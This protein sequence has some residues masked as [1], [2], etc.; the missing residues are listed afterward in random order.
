MVGFAPGSA[1]KMMDERCR[2]VVAKLRDRSSGLRSAVQPLLDLQQ[3]LLESSRAGS[4]NPDHT[5]AGLLAIQD[6]IL[7]TLAA[8]YDALDA[9][10]RESELPFAEVDHTG[11]IVYANEAMARHIPQ[12][13]GRD[14]ISLFG[15]R[16]PDVGKA[17][18]REECASLRVELDCDGLPRQF[19]AEIGPLRDHEGKPGAYALLL[20]L[21]SE[22][23]RLDAALDAIMRADVTG[24][25]AFANNKALALLQL[26]REQ[27]LGTDLSQW[28][29]LREP[30]QGEPIARRIARWLEATDAITDNE[31][32]LKGAGRSHPINLAVVPSYDGPEQRSGILMTF[33]DATEDLA[34]E[35]LRRLLVSEKDPDTVI[36]EAICIV[37][38]VIPCDMATFATYSDDGQLCRA[39]LVEPRPDWHWGTRWFDVTPEGRAWLEGDETWSDDLAAMVRNLAPDQ[40]SDPVV[41]AVREEGLNKLVVLPVRGAG[42]IFRCSLSLLSSERTYGAA[43]LRAL[44]DLGLEELFLAVQAAMERQREACIQRLK[45][46]LNEAPTARALAKTLAQGVVRCFGWEYAGVFRIDR[47]AGEFE[48]FEQVDSTKDKKL[49]VESSYRQKLSDGMLGHCYRQEEVLVLPRIAVNGY[50]YDFIK[51]TG[52]QES[53]MTVPLRVNGRIEL[54]LDLEAS[55]ENAFAGPDKQLAEALVADC[56]QILASRWHEAIGHSLMDAIDQAAIIVDGVGTIRSVNGAARAIIGEARRVA[57]K[58]FGAAEDD[59][60]ALTAAALGGPTR[61]VLSPAPGV[62]VPT[63]A[64]VQPLHDDYGHRLWL[65]SNLLEQQLERDQH[66]LE[67]TVSE[68]ARQTRAPLLIADGLL[69]G[70]AGLLRDRGLAETCADLLDRAANQ[71][72]KADLTYDRLSDSLVARTEPA[73]PPERFEV[74]ELLRQTIERLPHDDATAIDAHLPEDRGFVVEGWPERLGYALR[75]LLGFLLLSGTD[76]RIAVTADIVEGVGLRIELKSH[77]TEATSALMP[78]GDVDPIAQGEEQARRTAALA[79]DS[80]ESVI[81]L[82]GGTL[83]MPDPDAAEAV[84]IVTLRPTSEAVP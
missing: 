51:T 55:Q 9:A 15:A 56:E 75:S 82:H 36:R 84:F 81:D 66:Y 6:R 39:Q 63:L 40:E 72:L 67:Q 69:R 8:R 83:E 43:D 7:A 14:F 35:A 25:I 45:K 13:F 24:K 41:R 12:P 42:G 57:L 53:A 19:R 21:R 16:A 46:E 20:G 23:L 17:M 22:E 37:R 2:D 28:L 18:A 3:R 79:P 70:A 50:K 5:L 60:G 80:V 62:R 4:T 71:L 34:R 27:V 32:A 48:L 59:R 33:R 30:G 74:I 78:S 65:F 11:R 54:I 77:R 61:I 1:D 26:Q 58:T 31:L 68:V 52:A 49:S 38:R 64:T 29:A 44:R 76:V 47:K 10:A 73:E